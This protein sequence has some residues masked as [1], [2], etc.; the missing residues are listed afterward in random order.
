MDALVFLLVAGMFLFMAD[1]VIRGF[2]WKPPPKP[3]HDIRLWTREQKLHMR[4][5][6][7]RHPNALA[8]GRQKYG[9]GLPPGHFRQ[10]LPKPGTDI[11]KELA[12]ALREL[13]EA[14][15]Q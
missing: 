15:K 7:M 3:P 4:D 11:F 9:K 5:F 12:E 1:T 10:P 2:L 6:F 14:E 8:R 13:E